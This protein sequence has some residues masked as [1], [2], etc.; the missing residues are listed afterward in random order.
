MRR[1]TNSSGKDGAAQRRVEPMA[2]IPAPTPIVYVR[3]IWSDRYPAR[4]EIESVI[5]IEAIKPWRVAEMC[6]NWLRNCGMI[7]RGP[8]EPFQE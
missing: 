4:E 7:V 6:P 5:S 1:L 2:I 3:E 8:V